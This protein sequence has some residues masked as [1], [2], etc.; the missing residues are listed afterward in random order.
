VDSSEAFDVR[1]LF[2]PTTDYPCKHNIPCGD[3]QYITW[4]MNINTGTTHSKRHRKEE[5]S[6]GKELTNNGQLFC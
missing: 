2:P 1:F 4:V 5:A 6:K 3:E